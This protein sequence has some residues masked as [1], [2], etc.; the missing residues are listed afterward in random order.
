[1]DNNVTWESGQNLTSYGCNTGDKTTFIAHG[2]H[3]VAEYVPGLVEKYLQYRGGCII[4]F[5]YSACIDNENYFQALE[6]WPSASAVI[7][8]KLIQIES[9]GFLPDNMLLYG[10]SLGAWVFIDAAINF[11]P[12][13]VGLIDGE[14]EKNK[15]N[16]I[17]FLK[18]FSP[19]V[20][21]KAGPGFDFI[22]KNDPKL[23]AKTLQCIDTSNLLGSNIH[24]NCHKNWLMGKKIRFPV[25]SVD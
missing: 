11:G 5:N 12:Q 14:I 6:D 18:K 25:Y 4:Y 7:T 10:H 2:W 17:E 24:D 8:Q 23:S 1:M 9:E 19:A 21:D 20:C 13:K 22:Y 3:D 16:Q 15:N